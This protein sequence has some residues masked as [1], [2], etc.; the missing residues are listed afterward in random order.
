MSRL[1]LHE[2]L[3]LPAAGAFNAGIGA[4]P[5][6]SLN[7]GIPLDKLRAIR[8]P[9]LFTTSDYDPFFSKGVLDGVGARRPF[10]LSAAKS[11][12]FTAV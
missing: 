6:N 3:Y 1:D 8:C 4:A 9:V 5:P 12:R 10:L 2:R 7:A 11:G